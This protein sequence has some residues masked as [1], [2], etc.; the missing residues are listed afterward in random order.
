MTVP[1]EFAGWSMGELNSRRGC[2]IGMDVQHGNVVIRGSVPTTEYEALADAIAVA[3]KVSAGLNARG[4]SQTNFDKADRHN[5]VQVLNCRKQAI[6]LK[7]PVM[8]VDG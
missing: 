1:E 2:I 7:T 8:E 6:T 4:R 3:T 5:W